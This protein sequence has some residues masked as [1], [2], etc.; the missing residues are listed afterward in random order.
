MPDDLPSPATAAVATAR[1]EYLRPLTTSGMPGERPAA[2]PPP[3]AT[4]TPLV[5]RAT[6]PNI[7]QV[8]VDALG[9]GRLVVRPDGIVWEVAKPEDR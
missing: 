9:P 1:A 3:A 6:T 4:T 2:G 5:L 8:S 7:G